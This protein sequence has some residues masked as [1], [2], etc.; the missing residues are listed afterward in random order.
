MIN[1]LL[2]E[3]KNNC[4]KVELIS[5]NI[6]MIFLNKERRNGLCQSN[7]DI[8]YLNGNLAEYKNIA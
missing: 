4:L 5:Q 3:E 6:L 7:K 8:K 1:L 2:E